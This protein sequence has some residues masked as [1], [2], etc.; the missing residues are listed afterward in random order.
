MSVTAVGQVGAN[1]GWCVEVEHVCHMPTERR[2]LAFNGAEVK[3][4]SEHGGVCKRGAVASGRGR[5]PSGRGGGQV[6]LFQNGRNSIP[7]PPEQQPLGYTPSGCRTRQAASLGTP[8]SH[9]RRGPAHSTLRRYSDSSPGVGAGLGRVPP[10]PWR[11]NARRIQGFGVTTSPASGTP[12]SV[13][14]LRLQGFRPS[15]AAPG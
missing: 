8:S 14:V 10:A 12:L 1:D 5:W 9:R 15:A 11:M 13:T 2:S 7:I 6:P 3:Y 4:D